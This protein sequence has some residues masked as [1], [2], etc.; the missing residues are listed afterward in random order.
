MKPL[1]KTYLW[2]PY[3]F[4]EENQKLLALSYKFDMFKN[5]K[6]N[7]K[8]TPKYLTWQTLFDSIPTMLYEKASTTNELRPTT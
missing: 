3:N 7:D 8:T 5:D 4:F 1:N 2:I 6:S